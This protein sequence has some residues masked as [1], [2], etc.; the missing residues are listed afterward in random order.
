MDKQE[1]KAGVSSAAVLVSLGFFFFFI[2]PSDIKISHAQ[3]DLIST[4]GL[5]TKESSAAGCGFNGVN[6]RQSR[7]SSG[8]LA[9]EL[10]KQ[11]RLRLDAEVSDSL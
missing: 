1:T 9:V 6:A 11:P 10:F 2:K 8:A 5:R 3:M 7:S 4:A